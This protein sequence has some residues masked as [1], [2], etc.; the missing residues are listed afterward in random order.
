MVSIGLLAISCGLVIDVLVSDAQSQRSM[1]SLECEPLSSFEGASLLAAIIGSE[2]ANR[3]GLSPY[4][5]CSVG[6]VVKCNCLMEFSVR[7]F[8]SVPVSAQFDSPRLGD[9]VFD[10]RAFRESI[11]GIP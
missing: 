10:G 1:E 9:R 4:S 2:R 5:D 7:V 11:T 6:G 3:I 8:F